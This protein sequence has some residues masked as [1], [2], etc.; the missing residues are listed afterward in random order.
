MD[1]NSTPGALRTHI[2][3]F[4][5]RNAGKSSLVNAITNQN[6]SIVSNTKGTTTDPVRKSMEIL[7]LGPVVII[8]TPGIDDEG[9]LGEMRVKKTK[10]ILKETDVA[11]LVVDFTT[12]ITA[13]DQE[14]INIF[15]EKKLPYIIAYNK[16]DLCEKS[17]NNVGVSTNKTK[18][19]ALSTLQQNDCSTSLKNEI[20][21]SAKNNT[22]IYE[23]K[24]MIGHIIKNDSSVERTLL[25]GLI[26]P[27]DIVV[28]VI[29]ID[30]S[31][32]KGRLILPQQQVLRD[33]L[34]KHAIPLCC[35]VNELPHL[36][37]SLNKAP[38]L[39][40]TDSQAFKEVDKLTP[41]DISLTSFSILMA[42][43]KGNLKEL[44]HGAKKLEELNNGDTI[45]I[46]EGCTH[47]RQCNDIGT[48]KMPN[49]INSFTQKQLNYEFTSGKEFPDNL[50]KYSLIVHCGGCMLNS[51]EMLSRI[52]TA[53]K[54]GVPIVNYGI[55]IAHM[56]GILAR[57][58]DIFPIYKKI[59]Y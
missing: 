54:E 58:I 8:D 26:E 17:C 55:A 7:P 4:G 25:E 50:S 16:A 33:A 32:P 21:V 23:L 2:S 49:W 18:S 5:I 3:F 41:S 53:K 14:L 11:I 52:E 29:P 1:L 30:S 42:R 31:A 6:V 57:S 38:K 9:H 47:H 51:K 34:D 39:V 43:F 28:L 46:S 22:N 13:L 12:G 15:V 36:L 19:Q 24:E 48:V 45:L 44:I 27:N 20:F 37:A 40:I 35:Q 56:H 10:D 59:L